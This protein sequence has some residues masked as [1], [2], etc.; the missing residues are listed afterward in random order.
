MASWDEYCKEVMGLSNELRQFQRYLQAADSPES[1]TVSRKK[2]SSKNKR[3]TIQKKKGSKK[4]KKSR[5][6]TAED[7]DDEEDQD[8]SG[9]SDDESDGSESEVE[10]K[11]KAKKGGSKKPR[12]KKVPSFEKIKVKT[13]DKIEKDPATSKD[14][15]SVPVQSEVTEKKPVTSAPRGPRG[16]LF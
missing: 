3:Q 1:H 16:P 12:G 13:I 7:E 6:H 9:A 8:G 4:T 10:V 2:S 11:F 15:E 5:F 14:K